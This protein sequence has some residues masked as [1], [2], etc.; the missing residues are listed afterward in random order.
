M[1]CQTCRVLLVESLTEFIGLD[2]A[3]SLLVSTLVERFP[4]ARSMREGHFNR[5]N[6]MTKCSGLQICIKDGL[7]GLVKK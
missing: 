7:V 4:E 2:S 3:N 6:G 1:K 5:K